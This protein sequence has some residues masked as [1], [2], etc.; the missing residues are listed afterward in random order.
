MRTALLVIGVLLVVCLL[1]VA[2]VSRPAAP[3]PLPERV[4]GYTLRAHVFGPEA[5]AEIRRMH[6]GTFPLTAAAIG[7]YGNGD[8][9][10]W[11]GQTWGR[12]GAW[13]LERSMTAAI[14]RTESPFLP[15]GERLVNGVH[16]YELEG[17]GQRHF[18]FRVG[19]RVYWL[20]VSPERAEQALAEVIRF[21]KK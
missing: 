14:S 18:Y 21:A 12:P 9:V 2:L 13:A 7:V 11:V 10:L 16:V 3:L 8:A 20:A 6:R 15:V 4:A 5:A 19:N 1:V 17:M